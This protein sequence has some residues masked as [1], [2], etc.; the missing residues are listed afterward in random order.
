VLDQ[1]KAALRRDFGFDA[2]PFADAV[3]IDDVM[4]CIHTVPGVVA[5]DVDA[6]YRDGQPVQ[7]SATLVALPPELQSDGS[8]T[9][10]ELLYLND[11]P[12]ELTSVQLEVA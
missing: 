7:L 11:A 4:A 2:R 10:A 8:T 1:V 12:I 3:S 5:V 6:F 9:A